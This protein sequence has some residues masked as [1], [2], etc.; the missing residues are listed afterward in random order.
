MRYFKFFWDTHKWTGIISA[1]FFLIISVTG[2]LL[3]LKKEF[4]IL[5]PS[6]QKSVT[7]EYELHDFKPMHDVFEAVFAKNNPN[8]KSLAD[9][10]RVDFRPKHRTYKVRSIHDNQEYQVDALTGEVYYDDS[11]PRWADWLETIHDGS[12]ISDGFKVWFMPLVAL[13]LL[14]L[15]VSGLYLWLA[16]LFKKRARLRKKKA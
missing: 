14:F 5:Q 11:K 6:S 1:V 7:E 3:L 16:P 8:F 2:F 9:I 12:I 10:D 15:V 4:D 13:S